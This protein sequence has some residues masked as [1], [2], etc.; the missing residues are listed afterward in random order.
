MRARAL[1]TWLGGEED[2][3]WHRGI[4][5]WHTGTGT[6]HPRCIAVATRAQLSY[7]RYRPWIGLGAID[8]LERERPRRPKSWLCRV[9]AMLTLLLFALLS[10]SLGG[11]RL[12]STGEQLAW[13]GVGLHSQD[14]PTPTGTPST[15][16]PSP[17]NGSA[18]V[19][20]GASARIEYPG[21]DVE[22]A[23]ASV[24][25]WYPQVL[26]VPHLSECAEGSSSDFV[27][28]T[29]Y[30][31]ADLRHSSWVQDSD[32]YL[33]ALTRLLTSCARFSICCMALEINVTALIQVAE[34]FY[35][36]NISG[37]L[38]THET[39]R[40]AAFALPDVNRRARFLAIALKPAA[41]LVAA[42]ALGRPVLYLDCDMELV[43][44]PSLVTPLGAAAVAVQRALMSKD[45]P[46]PPPL[47]FGIDLNDGGA[48][49]RVY[50]WQRTLG[51][52][53]RPRL[54]AASGVVFV[55]ATDAA[56][57][58]VAA[59]ARAQLSGANMLSPDDQMLD[60]IFM[61][62]GYSHRARW[63]WLPPEY[64]PISNSSA[65]DRNALVINH[66]RG[67]RPGAHGGNSNL[68]P[69]L[70]AVM[71]KEAAIAAAVAMAAHAKANPH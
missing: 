43:A 2:A 52:A 9:V 20:G 69:K 37:E 24:P 36:E 47:G 57:L 44:W 48:D 62:A 15:S 35:G 39:W 59:W 66:D 49:V 70:P 30:T 23:R 10:L 21:L 25:S 7:P 40:S 42:S 13:R 63:G 11:A 54:K 27:G 65:L 33:D 26:R 32:V 17:S 58:I 34:T 38:A 6:P 19:G 12:A 18:M 4:N 28:L 55:N 14:S 61:E 50:N 67:R 1:T 29:L 51:G 16:Y 5:D 41:I 68:K 45:S 46:L 31:H 71:A 64:L 3:D 8:E 56:R 60:L 53:P 22:T